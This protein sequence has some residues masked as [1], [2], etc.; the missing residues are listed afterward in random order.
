MPTAIQQIICPSAE[1]LLLKLGRTNSLW[2]ETQQ[3]WA[4]R[5]HSDDSYKLIPNAL[6]DSPK[7]TLGYTFA[8]KEGIQPTNQDQIDA[9]FQRLH[10]FHWSIDAQGLHVP[11]DSN[12]LRTP[13]GWLDLKNKIENHGWPVD[14]LLPLLALAQHYEVPT[15]LLDWSDKPLVAAYFAAKKA[16]IEVSK[17]ATENRSSFMSVWAL[18]LDWI[19][20]KAFPSDSKGKMAVYVVSAPRATNPN[21]HAQGG[22]FT[23]G[24]LTKDEL[25]NGVT[26]EPVD[27]IVEKR[28]NSLRCNDPVMGHFTLPCSEARKLLRLLNREGINAATIYPGYKG[29]A[30]ALAERKLWDIRE[31]TTYWINPK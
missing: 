6:R 1:E 17:E 5:G 12:L 15:R 14:E 19:M 24:I 4:F 10:E 23:T 31:R 28:W 16:A 18:N 11:G 27:A 26:I 8:P 30:E 25:H 22:I 7:A 13:K 21:L 29:V 20:R 9:E 3:F 2:G